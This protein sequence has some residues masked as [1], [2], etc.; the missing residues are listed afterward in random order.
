MWWNQKY[1]KYL[2]ILNLQALFHAHFDFFLFMLKHNSEV[3]T[4][5]NFIFG[6]LQYVKLSRSFESMFR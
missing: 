4:K 6:I 5:W 1:L 3:E 2:F